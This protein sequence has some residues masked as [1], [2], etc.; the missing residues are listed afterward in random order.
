MVDWLKLAVDVEEET[1][2]QVNQD[3]SLIKHK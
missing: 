3:I 1:K 2:Q